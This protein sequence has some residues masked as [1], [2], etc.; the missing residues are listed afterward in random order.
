MVD[1]NRVRP[2]AE[3]A[4]RSAC[5]TAGAERRQCA[6]LVTPKHVDFASEVRFGPCNSREYEEMTDCGTERWEF[7]MRS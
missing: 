6:Q 7:P 2:N 3:L 1:E 4:C 5:F